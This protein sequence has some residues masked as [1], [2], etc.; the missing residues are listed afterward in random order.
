MK[1]DNFIASGRGFQRLSEKVDKA[2]KYK[3]MKEI[4][5]P[6]ERQRNKAIYQVLAK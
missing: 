4:A 6:K 2:R 5:S 1:S 3:G